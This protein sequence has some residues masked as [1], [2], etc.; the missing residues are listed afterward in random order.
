MQTDTKNWFIHGEKTVNEWQMKMKSFLIFVFMPL[1]AVQVLVTFILLW[2]DSDISKKFGWIFEC[3]NYY[4]LT[5]LFY[6][7]GAEQPY[8]QMIYHLLGEILQSATLYFF[9]SSCVW[10]I[11]PLII[12]WL[13]IKTVATLE[14]EYV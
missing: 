3:V 4:G 14:D 10:V 2:L 7:P 8:K 1:V 5:I 13:K 9:L 6:A 12:K 11:S